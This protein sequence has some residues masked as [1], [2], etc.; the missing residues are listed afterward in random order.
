MTPNESDSTDLENRALAGDESA[1]A[2]VFDRHRD[3]LRRMVRLRLDPRLAGR[4]D[5]DDVLQDAYLEIHRN[6]HT[7]WERYADSMPLRLWFRLVT[8]QKLIDLHRFHLGTAARDAGLEI[9]LHHG[10]WPRTSSASLAAKLLGKL[11]SA[12]KAAIRAERKRIVQEALNGMDPIDREVLV[13]RHFEQMRNDEVAQ[14]LGLRKTA[15]SQRYV[16]A[17]QRLGEILKAI[18]GLCEPP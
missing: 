9:S 11:T 8:S 2:D 17:L 16:R 7:Y 3:G 15:A 18:P 10:A 12:A 13:L 4:V 5:P 14:L 6:L 1:L